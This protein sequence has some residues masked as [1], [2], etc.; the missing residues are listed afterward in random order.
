VEQYTVCI[1]FT[2]NGM[3]SLSSNEPFNMRTFQ[4]K[5]R[6]LKSHVLV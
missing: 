1:D 2:S 5:T 6:I 4:I 3:V